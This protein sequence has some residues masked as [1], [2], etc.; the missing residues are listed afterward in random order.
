V[1]QPLAFSLSLRLILHACS[2]RKPIVHV[3][4]CNVQ[5]QRVRDIQNQSPLKQC[6]WNLHHPLIQQIQTFHSIHFT[7]F[8]FQT[9]QMITSAM[10][11]TAIESLH[12]ITRWILKNSSTKRRW[13]N[14]HG[15]L[16]CQRS[17]IRMQ[18]FGRR[19]PVHET[20]LSTNGAEKCILNELARVLFPSS[21]TC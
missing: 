8:L 17:R 12:E 7:S 19:K 2:W 1:L 5:S 6:D 9:G 3:D 20:I 4:L 13:S 10:I 18:I 15:S 11:K 21:P 16:A 14:V